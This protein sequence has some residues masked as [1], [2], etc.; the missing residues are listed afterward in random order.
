[1]NIVGVVRGSSLKRVEIAKSVQTKIWANFRA[2]ARATISHIDPTVSAN[3]AATAP[4]A[5]VRN[6]GVFSPSPPPLPFL[7]GLVCRLLMSTYLPAASLLPSAWV[8]SW[9]GSK[10]VWTLR[11][12]EGEWGWR[13]FLKSTRGGSDSPSLPHGEEPQ[14]II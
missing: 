2:K 5:L 4:A 6:L 3:G 13:A 11:G 9:L 1:M 10:I 14:G 8:G 7:L 12:S